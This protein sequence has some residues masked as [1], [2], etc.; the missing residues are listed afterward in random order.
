MIDTILVLLTVGILQG[1]PG[2]I[3]DGGLSNNIFVKFRDE[4]SV[5]ER[6][7]L[8]LREVPQMKSVHFYENIPDL[9]LM[10][11]PQK[12]TPEEAS[13]IT[14]NLKKNDAFEF[15]EQDRMFVA[16]RNEIIPNDSGFSQLWGHRNIG[17]NGGQVG[18]DMNSTM[19][20][21]ITQGS[22]DVRVMIIETGVQMNHPDLNLSEE[23][24][25]TTGVV[26]GVPSSGSLNACDNHGTCVAGVISGRI[27]NFV[28]TV[29]LSPSS[30]VVSAKVG[31]ANV[32]CDGSW[33]GQTSW[34][35]NA[36]NWAVS[37]GVRVTNNSNSYGSYS[38]TL[39][40][41]YSSTKNAGLVH[42][43]SSGNNGI[44]SISYPAAYS[45]VNAIGSVNRRGERSTFSNYGSALF[46]VAPGESIY[47][48]D[49]TGSVGYSSS[50][51]VSI[52]GTSFSSPYAAALAALILSRNP[53]LT[54]SQVEQIMRESAVDLGTNGF[55]SLMGWGMLDA[56]EALLNTPSPHC[57]GDLTE[58]DEVNGADLAV[59]LGEW[60][61][62]V[63]C[64]S[65]V[66][67]DGE[68]NGTDLSLVLGA[69]GSCD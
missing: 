48:T 63:D 58:D 23:R 13:V 38:S 36:L 9:A 5:E 24:D 4:S 26:N 64:V 27:N 39:N 51:Y 16:R 60:G 29:G 15:V 68:V 44:N 61:S 21:T 57:Q 56:H 33:F 30:P 43:A 3:R 20:W 28:G 50:S 67:E 10:S 7:A 17:Q 69:W 46:M 45:S 22:P 47:T 18:F 54:P 52:D 34:T 62:C 35:V 32:P 6:T 2:V 8:L 41:A 66:N 14:R 53:D 59:L 31:L 1:V 12:T 37:N 65:D 19:A 25:F 42:F 11:L 49:R 40:F 55:D